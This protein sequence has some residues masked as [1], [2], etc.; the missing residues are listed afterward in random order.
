MTRFKE[1]TRTSVVFGALMRSD[2]LMTGRQL[3]EAT[4]L[5]SH[6]VFGSL[7]MLRNYHAVESLEDNGTLWWFATPDSDQRSCVREERTPEKRPRRASRRRNERPQGNK[8]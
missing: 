3:M 4:G 7:A 5:S 8:E 1:R 2:E 6:D